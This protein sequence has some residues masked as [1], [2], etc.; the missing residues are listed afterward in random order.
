MLVGRTRVVPAVLQCVTPHSLCPEFTVRKQQHSLL[1]NNVWHGRLY[2]LC[3]FYC[4]FCCCVPLKVRIHRKTI[5]IPAALATVAM[6]VLMLEYIVIVLVV[7]QRYL[8]LLCLNSSSLARGRCWCMIR[9]L[10]PV[11]VNIFLGFQRAYYK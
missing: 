5:E 4:L 7:G 9:I 11:W 6:V 10:R 1:G 3:E 8:L 2:V